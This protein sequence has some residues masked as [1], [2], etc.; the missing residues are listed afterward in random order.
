[1]I[2]LDVIQRGTFRACIERSFADVSFAL[3]ATSRFDRAMNRDKRITAFHEGWAT[4]W[5][6]FFAGALLPGNTT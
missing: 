2:S 5:N 3:I 4:V 6:H 1:M